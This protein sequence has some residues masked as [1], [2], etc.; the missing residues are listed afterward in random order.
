M[1]SDASIFGIILLKN[2]D[3]P[4]VELAA[5]P[6]SFLTHGHCQGT[7]CCNRHAE[8]SLMLRVF[9]VTTTQSSAFM[10]FVRHEAATA[11][12]FRGTQKAWTFI[13]SLV[14]QLGMPRILQ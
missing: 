6:V 5:A 7:N 4:S 1:T 9:L 3:G 14:A 10:E 11:L 13:A 12:A 8:K 2:V